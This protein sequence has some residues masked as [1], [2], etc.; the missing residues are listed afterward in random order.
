M[1][2][3]LIELYAKREKVKGYNSK[4]VLVIKAKKDI[5]SDGPLLIDIEVERDIS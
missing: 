1:T 2:K 4:C 3:E 5:Y